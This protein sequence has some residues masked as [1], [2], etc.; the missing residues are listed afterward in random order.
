MLVNVV[1]TTTFWQTFTSL[2]NVILG[3][4]Y[5][6]FKLYIIIGRDKSRSLEIFPFLLEHLGWILSFSRMIFQKPKKHRWQIS[7]K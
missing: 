4:V 2:L 1:R 3:L 5:A 7:K 6:N